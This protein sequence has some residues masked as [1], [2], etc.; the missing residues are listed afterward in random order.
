MGS[1]GRLNRAF[2]SNQNKRYDGGKT[3]GTQTSRAAESAKMDKAFDEANRLVK[4]KGEVI[5]IRLE[6]VCNE[7]GGPIVG[8]TLMPFHGMVGE[9]VMHDQPMAVALH[10]VE[11]L[12]KLGK[13][14]VP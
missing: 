11:E 8:Y 4:E 3:Q 2:K 6:A 1:K 10:V 12:A 14:V 13:L 7:P 9:H 5:F